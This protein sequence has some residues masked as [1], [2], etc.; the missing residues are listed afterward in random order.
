[1]EGHLVVQ[2]CFWIRRS[3]PKVVSWSNTDIVS[4][5]CSHFISDYQY[6]HFFPEPVIMMRDSLNSW[7]KKIKIK[8]I[9]KLDGWSHPHMY[10]VIFPPAN[11]NFLDY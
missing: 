11:Q 1:M 8:I 4:K 10:C 5:E 2:R 3:V 7:N 6:F 9:A